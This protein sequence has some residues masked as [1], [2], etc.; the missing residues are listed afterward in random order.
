M[1]KHNF[2]TMDT[3]ITVHKRSLQR[4][5]F[6]MCLSFCPRRRGRWYPSMPS[7]SP[8]PHPRGRLRGLVRGLSRPTPRRGV[9][10]PAC[11]EAD[12]PQAD[13]YCCGRYA[14]YWNAFLFTVHLN[15]PIFQIGSIMLQM[16]R[17]V[18]LLLLLISVAKDF[19]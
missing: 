14:S 15:Q 1:A 17:F 16:S 10:I 11:T 8:G 9:C 5:C 6:Y 4:L 18:V 12:T 7:R 13:G 3:I 2:T 19:Q